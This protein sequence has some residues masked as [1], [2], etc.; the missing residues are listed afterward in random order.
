MNIRY[1]K[2]DGN[3]TD[4]NLSIRNTP[5]I[6]N[7]KYL[8]RHPELK[9]RICSSVD[10][11]IHVF[12]V[13]ILENHVGYLNSGDV[14]GVTCNNLG[15]PNDKL[16]HGY[17]GSMLLEQLEQTYSINIRLD[18]MLI[19]VAS[20]GEDQTWFDYFPDKSTIKEINLR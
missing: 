8:D 14:A 10:T 4:K 17:V 6:D 3:I 12:L 7:L 20:K 2:K 5:H 11:F 13:N 1:L 15:L 9:Q 16:H 18:N 19:I